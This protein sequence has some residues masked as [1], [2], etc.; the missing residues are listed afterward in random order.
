VEYTNKSNPQMTNIFKNQTVKIKNDDLKF[1]KA[2]INLDNFQ[3][4]RKK[5]K[6]FKTYRHKIT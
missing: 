4:S 5:T 1:I 6:E 2:K 3:F